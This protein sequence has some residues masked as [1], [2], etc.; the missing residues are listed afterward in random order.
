METVEEYFKWLHDRNE[1]SVEEIHKKETSR[2]KWEFTDTLYSFYG[3]FVVG[4]KIYS[5]KNNI[6]DFKEILKNEG[7]KVSNRQRESKTFFEEFVKYFSNEVKDEGIKIAVDEL[8][9]LDVL[10]KFLS[11]YTSIGNVFPIWPGG[12]EHRGK[13]GCYDIPDIYFND[14]EIVKYSQHFFNTYCTN[15]FMERIRYGKYCTL[16][17]DDLLNFSKD[18][19]I[20]FLIYIF[21][22]ICERE[23]NINTTLK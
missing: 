6:S 1:K 15:N 22:T 10:G 11:V 8:K 14:K 9:N 23:K 20:D 21:E 17:S 19:Y 12:N 16:T 4:L 2:L 13:Y 5:G 7:I 3:I 18:K